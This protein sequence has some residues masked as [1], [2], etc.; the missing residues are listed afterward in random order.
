[1]ASGPDLDSV[2]ALLPWG[3]GWA[4]VLVIVAYTALGSLFVVPFVH[5]VARRRVPPGAHWTERVRLE[6]ASRQNRGVALLLAPVLLAM[7]AWSFT[8][9]FSWLPPAAVATL[10]YLAV[11]TTMA[12]ANWAVEQRTP[13]ARVSL[14]ESLRGGLTML[15]LLQWPIPVCLGIALWLPAQAGPRLWVGLTLSAGLLIFL[16]FGSGY[17]VLL[18]WLGWLRP[19]PPPLANLVREAAADYGVDPTTF[20]ARAHHANAFAVPLRGVVVFT[21]GARRILDEEELRA[22]AHHELSHLAEPR[23]VTLRRFLPLLPLVVL[24]ASRPIAHHFG[25]SGFMIA[26]LG[27]LVFVLGSVKMARRL[28]VLADT[29]ARDHL[30]GAVYARALEKLY[31][32]NRVPAVLRDRLRVHPDLYDRLVAAGH[33]PAY[34][35]PARPP[36][37]LSGVLALAFILGWMLGPFGAHLRLNA[38]GSFGERA[39][40]QAVVLTG[41]QAFSLA[42]LAWH[43]R[44]AGQIEDAAA[45]WRAARELEPG[46]NIG[47]LAELATSLADLGRTADARAELERAREIFRT[48][49]ELPFTEWDDRVLT[50]VERY[51]REVEQGGAEASQ[52]PARH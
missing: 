34:P 17:L 22:V 42:N 7:S 19:A 3:V 50:E 18:R 28:E 10:I 20:V 21:E 43:R 2:R 12:I 40:V 44:A 31:R 37:S 51:L 4:C 23:A 24:A 38:W 41:G 26:I 46:S 48:R 29:D 45:L 13:E 9:P 33:T 30:D 39:A 16:V 32:E 14:G 52:R 35:R 11:Y 27:A 5:F 36:R 1:M 15:L 47:W 49:P 25:T 8:G 6:W